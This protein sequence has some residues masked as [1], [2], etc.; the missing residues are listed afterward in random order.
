MG[1]T[2][3]MQ[4]L[5]SNP[6]ALAVSIVLHA[7]VLILLGINLSNNEPPKTPGNKQQIVKAFM[8]D[9]N[10][11]DQEIAK[12]KQAEI[13]K[14]NAIEKEKE[15][16]RQQVEKEKQRLAEIGRAHV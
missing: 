4:S 11:V 6:A 7:V 2:G 9:A 1:A 15:R 13:D 12:L 8:V 10:V 16:L 3:L 14:K 5:K